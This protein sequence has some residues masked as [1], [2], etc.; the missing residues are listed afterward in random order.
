MYIHTQRSKQK[1]KCALF[2]A[3]AGGLGPA[4]AQAVCGRAESPAEGFLR[5]AGAVRLHA[6]AGRGGHRPAETRA[7]GS[8]VLTE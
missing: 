3:C 2:F 1:Q 5:A 6:Q 7:I 8:L 4:G